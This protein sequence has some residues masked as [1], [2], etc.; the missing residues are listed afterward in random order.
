MIKYLTAEIETTLVSKNTKQERELLNTETRF[1][2][3]YVMSEQTPS[4]A[5]NGELW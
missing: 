5:G 3:K 4:A 2:I 1:F